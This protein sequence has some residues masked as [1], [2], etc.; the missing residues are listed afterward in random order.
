MPLIFSPADLGELHQPFLPRPRSVFL[1]IQLGGKIAPSISHMTA[2]TRTVLSD[3]NF[4]PVTAVDVRRTSDYLVKIIDLIRGCGF[5]IAIFGDRT[6]ART[7]GNI[8]FEIGVAGVLG[9]PVQLLLTG[10]NP[11]TSPAP[12][13]FVRT[14]WIRYADGEDARFEQ[15]FREAVMEIEAS[16]NY[17][18]QLGDIALTAPDLELAF[19]RFKQAVLIANDVR[20]RLR[21]AEIRE[22]LT[23]GFARR[24]VAVDDLASHRTRL[25][26]AINEFLS[27]LPPP[28]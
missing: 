19:E 10:R 21:I 5:G 28:P 22:R 7:L 9:K 24:R 3:N 1:M 25:L 27:L 17:Y 13:D 11:R 16:A 8:F 23:A 14:E 12:S 26:S 2:I 6:P 18:R 20:S 4:N 15:E